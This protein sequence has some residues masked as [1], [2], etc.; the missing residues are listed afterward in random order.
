MGRGARE[1]TAAEEAAWGVEMGA[2][3]EGGGK[4]EP[5]AVGGEAQAAADGVR[6]DAG[7]ARRRSTGEAAALRR[8]DAAAA[9]EH[10]CAMRHAVAAIPAALASLCSPAAAGARNGG[11]EGLDPAQGGE[12]AGRNLTSS[13]N[14]HKVSLEEHVEAE[15]GSHVDDDTEF[16]DSVR[17]YVNGFLA[18]YTTATKLN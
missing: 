13:A 5:A 2:R 7:T 12:E 9:A 16:L 11:G 10:M 14:D 17:L 18:V 15:W 4:V 8:W 1:E 6:A 3:G